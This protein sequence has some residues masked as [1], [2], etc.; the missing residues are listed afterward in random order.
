MPEERWKGLG[1]HDLGLVLADGTGFGFGLPFWARWRRGMGL[2][3][4][5]PHVK[6]VVV[7][8]AGGR[9]MLLGACLGPPQSWERRLLGQ[10]LGP[11]QGWGR[12]CGPW[13]MPS[14]A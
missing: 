5:R 6:G 9:R 7:G 3:R 10:R 13:P 4:L 12:A 11:A 2:R 14:T 8:V 1:R